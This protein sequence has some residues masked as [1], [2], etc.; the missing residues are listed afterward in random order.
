MLGHPLAS[1][2]PQ[3]LGM[4]RIPQFGLPPA[5]ST[6]ELDAAERAKGRSHRS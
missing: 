5:L 2:L 4:D 3:G 6:T 1:K